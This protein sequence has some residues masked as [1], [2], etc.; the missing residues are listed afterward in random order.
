MDIVLDKSFLHGSSKD[1]LQKLFSGNE[2]LMPEALFYE[3]LTTTPEKRIKCFR[4][5]P[6]VINPVVLIPNIGALI[7]FEI[8]NRTPCTPV[9]RLAVDVPYQFNSNLCNTD[10]V[11]PLKQAESLEEW[12]EDTKKD[13]E[14]FKQCSA[15]V[16]EWFPSLA[17]YRPGQ[18]P[19]VI[20]AAEDAITNDESLVRSLYDEIRH[21]DFPEGTIIGH[22]WTLFRRVQVYFL[23]AIE[24]IRRFGPDNTSSKQAGIENDFH[25]IQYCITG[26]QAGGLASKDKRMM[27]VFNK[28][29]PEGVL[30]K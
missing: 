22:D 24:Y 21:P 16:Y 14:G 20:V 4:R 30:I 10:Y 1:E 12:K 28:I 26:V 5:L 7:S 6:N 8:T 23:A 9:R 27:E 13:I 25:D 2:V 11:I 29:C 19:S 15:I 17:T 3:L 18:N